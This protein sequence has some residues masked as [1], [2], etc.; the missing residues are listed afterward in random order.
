MAFF[1]R[2]FGWEAERVPFEGHI[3]HYTLNTAVAVRILDD[4]AAAPLVPNYRVSDLEQTIRSIEAAGGDVARSETTPDGGGWARALDDQ[5]LPL[6]VFRPNDRYH[7]QPTKTATGDVGLVFIRAD[8][9]RAERFYASVLGWRLE[10]AH[11][12]TQYFHATPRVG[13]FDE[14]AAFGR[15]VVRSATLYISVDT[16]STALA[17][18]EE[19]GGTTG[20][21]AQDMGPYFTAICTDDQGTE[22]GLMAE[23]LEGE[24]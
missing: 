19:L 1:E 7:T 16:L 6:L 21:A 5:G 24:P 23:T 4:P 10:R 9:R 20:P 17:R 14:A 12:D 3:S 11:P 15:D 8:A 13:V 18:I 22:F 2:L